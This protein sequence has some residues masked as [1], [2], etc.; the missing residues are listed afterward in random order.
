LR[1]L[2][3]GRA[4]KCPACDVE[5]RS[6]EKCAQAI[7]ILAFAQFTAPGAAKA[8]RAGLRHPGVRVKPRQARQTAHRRLLQCT[9]VR[10]RAGKCARIGFP[11]TIA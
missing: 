9:R 7:V 6:V 8:T 5:G 3:A 11:L 10:L 2:A 1:S 4:P